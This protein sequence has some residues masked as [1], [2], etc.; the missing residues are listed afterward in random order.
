MS[1]GQHSSISNSG[2]N[3]SPQFRRRRLLEAACLVMFGFCARSVY[4]MGCLNGGI[5]QQ[6]LAAGVPAESKGNEYRANHSQLS[7]TIVTV[8]NSNN[9]LPPLTEG[10]LEFIFSIGLEGTGHHF[11]GTVIKNS[12]A[13][14][15]IK[16]WNLLG[17]IKKAAVALFNQEELDGLWNM[18][19]NE[20]NM[21]T[22]T[23]RKWQ[24]SQPY[25]TNEQLRVAFDTV[26]KHQE[27][28][29]ILKT[30]QQKY[31]K[32]T[33]SS[34]HPKSLSVP[35]N[36][37]T[38]GNEKATGMMSYPNFRTKCLT[39]QYP[40]LELLYS[41]CADAGVQCSH[42]Y[43]YRHPL[44]V[45]KSTTAK[46][47][48]NSPG[49]VSATHLYTSQLKVIETQLLEFP[50]RTRGCF[51][52]FDREGMAE[53][54]TSLRDMWGW[55]T[56][57]QT[58]AF[59]AFI[60]DNYRKPSS[61]HLSTSDHIVAEEIEGVFPAEH[62]PFLELFLKAHERTLDICRQSLQRR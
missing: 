35:L 32:T 55:T 42:V 10:G 3:Q 18:V 34:N 9:T 5:L 8:H 2:K 30:I 19:C 45:L 25:K 52:F 28:V 53:W 62:L 26:K 38:A 57:N 54:Q 56:Q 36:T 37:Y 17:L 44:D 24:L 41:A 12:P 6:L 43:V 4:D 51:G 31:D 49:M 20:E 11:M 14:V 61:F 59:D 46:R 23:G 39:P 60:R 1:E 48:F 13:L 22:K 15:T 21:Y 16:S 29:D 58:N 27:L 7:R 47:P 33:K 40:I 50:D